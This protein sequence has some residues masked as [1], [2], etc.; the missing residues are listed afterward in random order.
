MYL[1][2]RRFNISYR[3]TDMFLKDIGDLTGEVAHKWSKMFMHGIFEE[4]IT[5]GRGGQAR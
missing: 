5:D 1:T 4:F 2:L 3:E